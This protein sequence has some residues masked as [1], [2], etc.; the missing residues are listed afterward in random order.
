MCVCVSDTDTYY[1]SVSL[2]LPHLLALPPL[3]GGGK[4]ERISLEASRDLGAS[5]LVSCDT[6][7]SSWALQLTV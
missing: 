3:S 5:C 7:L 4:V 2:L 1:P 6:V